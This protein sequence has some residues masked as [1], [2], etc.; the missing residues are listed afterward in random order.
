MEEV[1]WGLE[2][3]P[4]ACEIAPRRQPPTTPKYKAGLGPL[5]S[6]SQP[7]APTWP[8]LQAG[9]AARSAR[10]PQAPGLQAP[11][12]PIP[13]PALDP[14]GHCG[15]RRGPEVAASATPTPQRC[16]GPR[17]GSFSWG[18][19]G[20]PPDSLVSKAVMSSLPSSSAEL[21]LKAGTAALPHPPP[22]ADLGRKSVPQRQGWT[23]CTP[24]PR[25]PGGRAASWRSGA[26]LS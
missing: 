24:R 3:A 13:E 2:G 6:S 12:C 17:R 19:L 18:L 16:Q 20:L 15:I 11:C 26:S 14:G 9:T 10:P 4:R 1:F 21:G 5:S 7:A 8:R 22:A 25:S 23:P